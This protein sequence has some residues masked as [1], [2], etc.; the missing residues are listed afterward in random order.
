M[1]Q[2]DG[3]GKL[4]KDAT[5]GEPMDD[6]GNKIKVSGTVP[7]PSDSSVL[8][9]NNF[10]DLVT[11]CR[12]SRMCSPASPRSTWTTPP[13]GGRARNAA[14]EQKLIADEFVKSGYKIDALVLSVINSPSFMARKN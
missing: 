12:P 3:V 11:S 14:C 1:E 13:A 9:F 5:T 6:R 7:L 8:A 4:R 10:V 2:Y